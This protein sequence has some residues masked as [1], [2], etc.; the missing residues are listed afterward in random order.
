[1]FLYISNMRLATIAL[2]ASFSFSFLIASAQT[3]SVLLKLTVLDSYSKR[4]L[5]AVSIINPRTGSSSTTNNGMYEEKIDKKDVLF[6]FSPGYQT[7]KFSL[8][9]SAYRPAY[10][11]HYVLEP[12]STGLKGAVVIKAPKT[13]E[14]IEKERQSLGIT[15][16]EL[17]KPN[18]DPFSSPIGA[19]W[20]MLSARSKEREKLKKQMVEDDRRRIFKEL[21][22]YYNENGLIDLPETYYDDFIDYCNLS[23]DYLKTNTDYV[24]SRDIVA[25]YQKYG[26]HNGL[27]K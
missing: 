24:I 16:K 15:P 6:I 10:I 14:Q 21:L 11:L 22:R 25:L 4:P 27:I 20:D 9:D 23:L 7:V 19:L 12:L 17:D 1:M 5:S 26:R 2:S 8:A 13:L 18:I 3:D